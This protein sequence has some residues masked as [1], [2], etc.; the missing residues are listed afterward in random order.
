VRIEA[1]T[2]EELFEAGLK[3]MSNVL[4]KNFCNAN[5]EF[6]IEF[7]VTVKSTDTTALLVNFL[8]EV[9]T[10]SYAENIL[11]CNLSIS[12]LTDVRLI[13]TVYGA[14]TEA[15]DKDIKSITYHEADVM[16]NPEGNWETLLIFD[17]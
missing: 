16:K 1:D 5:A 6:K 8:S 17:I 3:S 14:A 4:K 7:E 13:A 12:E 15:F 10:K 2:L 9:L 11:F